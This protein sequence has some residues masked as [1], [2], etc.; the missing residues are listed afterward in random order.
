MRPARCRSRNSR[1]MIK[2][3]PVNCRTLFLCCAL[4]GVASA[5]LAV[6][7]CFAV[8]YTD[9]G[10]RTKSLVARHIYAIIKPSS[11]TSETQSIEN[12]D[13]AKSR[14]IDS[15]ARNQ[16]IEFYGFK[17][18]RGKI[19]D[20]IGSGNKLRYLYSDIDFIFVPESSYCPALDAP[21]VQ[22]IM[23]HHR[24]ICNRIV[25]ED[26]EQPLFSVLVKSGTDKNSR[27]LVIYNHG[28]NG[29]PAENEQFANQFIEGALAEGFDVL[30]VSM[31][32]TGLDI[33][34][35]DFRFKSWDGES[36]AS[37]D[38]IA[39]NFPYSHGIFELMDTGESHFMRYFIDTGVVAAFN[40]RGEYSS[41][42]Y[43]GLSGGATTGLYTC[44]VM[45]D[46]LDR[47]L[48][49]SGVMPINLRSSADSFGDAEQ[50]ASSFYSRNNIF[51]FVR[52]LSESS[53][54]LRLYY[55]SND[56]CCFKRASAEAFSKQ[57]T[58]KS[59]HVPFYIRESNSHGYDPEV[60]LQAL[61]S[62]GS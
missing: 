2:I 42:N 19:L 9:F 10:V 36:T 18:A 33:A 14:E 48:L 29:L 12:Y 53:V 57:L 55:S 56:S 37:S 23:S 59:I 35:H 58:E 47:C 44:V 43:V 60:I 31:P 17:N 26:I 8:N 21:F 4:S 49:I 51:D 41:I 1:K 30:L 5:I 16:S 6:A 61:T 20:F 54:D 62:K 52:A 39:T 11:S 13:E 22:R 45:Q 27:K 15:Q 40:L 46:I 38:Q 7:I 28:H 24:V 3:K 25:Y 32:F 50:V 34:K